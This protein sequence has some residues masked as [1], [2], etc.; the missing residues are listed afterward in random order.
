[1]HFVFFFET[2]ASSTYAKTQLVNVFVLLTKL[3]LGMTGG[4]STQAKM[5]VKLTAAFLSDLLRQ[6]V[7][8][9]RVF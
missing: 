1:M 8:K 3:W 6:V 5:N 7:F 4:L 2:A 9:H